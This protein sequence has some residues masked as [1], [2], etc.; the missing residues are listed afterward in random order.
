MDSFLFDSER[1]V[2][3]RYFSHS[4]FDTN[5]FAKYFALVEIW[6]KTIQLSLQLK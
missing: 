1:D 3:K 5:I 2:Q 4:Y 6:L